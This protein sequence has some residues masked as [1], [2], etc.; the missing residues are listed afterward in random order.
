MLNRALRGDLTASLGFPSRGEVSCPSDCREPVCRADD[1]VCHDQRW[2]SDEQP[3]QNMHFAS[4]P[5]ANAMMSVSQLGREGK[6]AKE[7]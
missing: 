5:H 4:T 6:A 3:K 7:V 1:A 2:N